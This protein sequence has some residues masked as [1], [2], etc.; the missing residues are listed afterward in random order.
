[1]DGVPS[2]NKIPV[3]DAN[4]VNYI[5]MNQQCEANAFGKGACKMYPVQESD[6]NPNSEEGFR[7]RYP[8]RSWRR[9][10]PGYRRRR[11]YNRY[12]LP[13][14]YSPPVVIDRPVYDYTTP[15]VVVVKDTQ[16][17]APAPSMTPLLVLAGVVAVGS[18]LALRK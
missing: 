4:G 6:V 18:I 14:Y 15:E 17:S 12:P 11:W 2:G 1:M 5:G 10:H 9:G 13:I 3:S 7:R 8:R 16:P